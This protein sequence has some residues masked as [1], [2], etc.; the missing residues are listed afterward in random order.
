MDLCCWKYLVKNLWGMPIKMAQ[1]DNI[2]TQWS[3]FS[4]TKKG[5]VRSC[6]PLTCCNSK[7]PTPGMRNCPKQSWTAIWASLLHLRVSLWKHG[8][9][10]TMLN[11]R[12]NPEYGNNPLSSAHWRHKTKMVVVELKSLK[13]LKRTCL[14]PDLHRTNLRH[15][16]NQRKI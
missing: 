12:L 6:M 9:L 10:R 8:I 11:N 7:N 15:F 14:D 4:V 13:K 16:G 1:V 2:W 5:T 3:T